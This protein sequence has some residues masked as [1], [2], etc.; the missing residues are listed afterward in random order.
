[1]E[2]WSWLTAES[3]SRTNDGFP[4]K[5]QLRVPSSKAICDGLEQE[6]EYR[7]RPNFGEMASLF[8]PRKISCIEDGNEVILARV[9]L[10]FIRKCISNHS[11][12]YLSNLLGPQVYSDYHRPT[13]GGRQTSALTPHTGM[14]LP[15]IQ[16]NYTK[17]FQTYMYLF[18]ISNQ[19]KNRV[20][21]SGGV[22]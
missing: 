21:G 5:M 1:M 14:R 20:D 10:Y 3:W 19:A 12:A 13:F 18:N 9:F 2:N 4:S 7:Q 8:R 17:I 6:K 16:R 22:D 11:R 15:L